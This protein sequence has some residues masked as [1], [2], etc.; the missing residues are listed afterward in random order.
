MY[1]DQANGN[2]QGSNHYNTFNNCTVTGNAGYAMWVLDNNNN[3]EINGGTYSGVAG[4]YVLAFGDSGPCCNNNVYIHNATIN[5][6]GSTGILIANG[7]ANACINNNT[8][9]SGLTAAIN[10]TAANDIGAG[11]VLN[12]LS[13]NLNAG[14]CGTPSVSVSISPS[15][16]TVASGGTQQFTA[17]VTGTSNTAVTWTASAGSISSSG[18]FTA[19]TVSAN[20][21][22]TVAATSQADTTKLA[23]AS[24]TVT[25]PT[26]PNTFGYAVR[27]ASVGTTMSNTITAA[28]YQMVG[29]NGTVTSM[30]VFIA[31]P[32]STSPNNQFQV[33]IYADN[34]GTPGTLIASSVPQTIVPDAWNTVSISVPVTANAF[35]WLAYN[36][37][38][39]AANANNLRFDAGGTT[40]AWIAPESFGTWPST[41]GPIAG[42]SSDALSMYATYK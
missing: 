33:A 11:N 18:L 32:V 28:R 26:P 41:Y 16:P 42:T 36:T 21:N 39:L 20:T 3:I 34:G 7:S 27:G 22:V 9:G 17:A 38:G 8:F 23:S 40:S 37:N 6:P 31:S 10:V 12:G 14:T 30:S 13:S 1:G 4:S 2:H 25:P 29:Q 5:G 19:P 15:A 24:V 35:Y